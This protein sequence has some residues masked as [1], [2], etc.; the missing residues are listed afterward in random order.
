MCAAGALWARRQ[1]RLLLLLLPVAG[2]GANR[3]LGYLPSCLQPTARTISP[4]MCARQVS[5]P[6]CLTAPLAWLP[7][8]L[9]KLASASLA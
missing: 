3:M 8:C 6:P 9:S 2:P 1:A 7:A 4:G 5:T